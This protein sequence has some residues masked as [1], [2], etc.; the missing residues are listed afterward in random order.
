MVKWLKCWNGERKWRDKVPVSCLYDLPIIPLFYES[1][2]IYLLSFIFCFLLLLLV[3]FGGRGDCFFKKVLDMV[4]GTL[5]RSTFRPTF[6]EH[7]YAPPQL[8]HKRRLVWDRRSD[9]ESHNGIWFLIRDVVV[10]L[11]GGWKNISLHIRNP[12]LGSQKI[13]RATKTK[14]ILWPPPRQIWPQAL[15]LLRTHGG[16]V[17]VGSGQQTLTVDRE[18]KKSI[19]TLVRQ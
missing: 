7:G 11:S 15:R 12:I 17:P 14:K 19:W 8:R 4:G 3:F 6:T 2:F 16:C 13:T 10:E 1:G 9:G 5:R 18:K